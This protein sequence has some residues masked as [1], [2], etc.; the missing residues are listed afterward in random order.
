MFHDLDNYVYLCNYY[1]EQY[2]EH[3]HQ[4]MKFLKFHSQI[5]IPVADANALISMYT[6]DHQLLSS[7][8]S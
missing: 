1:P 6:T 2:T 4:L 7:K 5:F 8:P 3:I